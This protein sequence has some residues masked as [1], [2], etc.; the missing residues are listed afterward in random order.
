ML[1]TSPLHGTRRKLAHMMMST[2]QFL[3][4]PTCMLRAPLLS[5]LYTPC[6]A[7]C[8]Q[9]MTHTL[10]RPELNAGEAS[11]FPTLAAAPPPS[12]PSHLHT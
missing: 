9:V 6:C 8:H 3:A 4:G 5:H 2:M 1:L 7:L 10:C 12:P 11:G